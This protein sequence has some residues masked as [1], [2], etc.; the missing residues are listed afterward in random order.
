MRVDTDKKH[1]ITG[2]FVTLVLFFA[3]LLCRNLFFNGATTYGFAFFITAGF[4]A[5]LCGMLSA[6]QFTWK[7][8][9][10]AVVHT[11]CFFLAPL[12][13]MLM[14]ECINDIFIYDFDNRTFLA[15]YIA[16]L[17]FYLLTYVI[18]G[19]V[20]F[21]ILLWSP[22]VFIFGIVN[23]Y[24]T[25]FR[26][27]PIVPLDIATVKTGL[28]VSSNYTY[29]INY[30]I[31][32]AFLLLCFLVILG[33]KLKK[34]SFSLKE[35]LLPRISSLAA[36]SVIL[37]AFYGTDLAADQG[38]K[39]DFWDQARGYRNYGTV[40]SF[41]LNTKYIRVSKP[42]G[43][44]S[45][46]IS[47]LLLTSIKDYSIKDRITGTDIENAPDPAGSFTLSDADGSPEISKHQKEKVT[48]HGLSVFS[49]SQNSP[50]KVEDKQTHTKQAPTA[51][52]AGSSQA[53][54]TDTA[55][56]FFSGTDASLINQAEKT[57]A[58][59]EDKSNP[60]IICIMNE[61][62][63][64]LNVLGKLDT[65]ADCMPFLHSLTKNTIKGNLY[66][67]VN[68]AGTSNTEFEFLTGNSMAFLPAGSNVYQLYLKHDQPSLA[69]TLGAQ[70]YSKGAF[71][72]Y[73]A[74]GWNRTTVY[75]LMGF[76]K[77]T[78]IEDMIDN[79][80]LED[81]KKANNVTVLQNGLDKQYPGEKLLL[82]RYISDDYDFKKIEQMYEEKEEGKPMFLFNVTMQN[83]GGYVVSYSNFFQKIYLN[84]QYPHYTRAN[85]YLSLVY[86]S[87]Q[88]FKHLVE[89][90]NQQKE[91]TIICMFGDHQPYLESSFFE[92][93]IGTGL[94]KLNIKQTQNRY[95]TPFV[96]WANYDIDEA[97]IDKISAN[98]LSTLVLQTAGV[99]LTSYNEYLSKLYQTL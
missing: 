55:S 24:V 39:P 66:V 88:A 30:R 81:Y 68:G 62:L 35:R 86:E 72:P 9:P 70:N 84:N 93:L 96:I 2:G 90:F 79:Q 26:G 56:T 29:H 76:D 42:T 74:S 22:V 12:L 1:L 75:P 46:D 63:A 20:R 67:P 91:P 41:C 80:V 92:S 38:L 73:Y 34:K 18:S 7:G 11:T 15:N 69:T 98:Y 40:L 57:P 13:S 4:L 43:Y 58:D 78:S 77:F 60:N 65:N 27:S 16:Y 50:A 82:R 59:S 87:D 14:L 45:D 61:S 21:S 25:D 94:D 37:G 28:N 99:K 8:K 5:L 31:V 71:H 64:D 53:D 97:Y 51:D 85:R 95:V 17:A 6:I 48:D 83:H 23:Y 32:I 89:Y 44:D 10:S 36:L 19:S 54:T 3:I 33:L 52:A 47:D 49:K